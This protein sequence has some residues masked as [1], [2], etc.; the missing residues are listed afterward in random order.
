MKIQKRPG[1]HLLSAAFAILLSALPL[2]S[3][4]RPNVV[5][6]LIDDISHY[7]VSAY[8]AKQ[9]N[10]TEDFFESVPVATP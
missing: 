6:I 1:K 3:D 4:E 10:S 8:G 7:G 2:H 5:F 9:L